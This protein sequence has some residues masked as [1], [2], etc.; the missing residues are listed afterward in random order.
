VQQL[1]MGKACSKISEDDV[2]EDSTTY[3]ALSN[4]GIPDDT[5]VE[6]WTTDDLLSYI[7]IHD[8]QRMINSDTLRNKHFTGQQVLQLQNLSQFEELKCM[9]K[10]YSKR[11]DDVQYVWQMI[12]KL[13]M[14]NLHIVEQS[15]LVLTESFGYDEEEDIH[16]CV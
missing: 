3:I 14:K 13:Q 11:I 9:N 7:R 15:P 10:P 4:S 2:T 12:V 1:F 8:K 16:S 5:S 6:S